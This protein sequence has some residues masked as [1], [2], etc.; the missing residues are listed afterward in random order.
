MGFDPKCVDESYDWS[1]LSGGQKQRISMARIFFHVLR[2]DRQKKT[3]IA[4]LDEAT[5]MMDET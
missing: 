5:S 2:T 4:I 3:P 1:S